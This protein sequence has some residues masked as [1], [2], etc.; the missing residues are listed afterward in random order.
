[1]VLKWFFFFVCLGYDIWNTA[2]CY[3]ILNE[4]KFILLKAYKLPFFILCCCL[5]FKWRALHLIKMNSSSN[6]ITKFDIIY[7]L[8]AR[9]CAHFSYIL[10][11]IS[12]DL[13]NKYLLYTYAIS[14]SYTVDDMEN[15]FYFFFII[16]V[17]LY[18]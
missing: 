7:A 16:W 12:F 9:M 14:L 8:Y 4:R 5:L 11:R 18:C 10:R 6:S 1:M 15:H 17:F 13:I 3:S 2:N